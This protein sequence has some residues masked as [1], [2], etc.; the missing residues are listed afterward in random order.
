M[1]SEEKII[2]IFLLGYYAV[3]TDDLGDIVEMNQLTQTSYEALLEEL[4]GAHLRIAS[5]N[6]S[7]KLLKC[8]RVIFF[9]L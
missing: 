4:R 5:T 6:V 7:A 3:L 9:D 2:I 8:L 1:S